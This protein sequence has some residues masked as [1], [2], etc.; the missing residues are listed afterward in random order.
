MKESQISER[1]LNNFEFEA[2]NN[3]ENFQF[4]LTGMLRS[5]D[6][7]NYLITADGTKFKV[8]NNRSDL[9]SRATGFWQ[10][11]PTIDNKGK[12]INLIVEK[13]ISS[14]EFLTKPFHLVIF[15]G[16][17]VQLSKKA[18]GVTV[19][20]KRTNKKT[21]KLTLLAAT[22]AMKVGQLWKF[23]AELKGNCLYIKKGHHLKD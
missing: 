22:K 12:L 13:K 10:V 2:K 20:V 21:L 1:E 4:I 17:I 15:E 11:E 23:V 14:E 5:E 19:K 7:T 18:G 9:P 16:R 6:N 3:L 8:K